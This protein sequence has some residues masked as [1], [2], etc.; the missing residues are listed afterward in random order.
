MDNFNSWDNYPKRGTGLPANTDPEYLDEQ[1]LPYLV[2]P[3]NGSNIGISQKGT[4]SKSFSTV[5]INLGMDFNIF[6]RSFNIVLNVF[7]NPNGTYDN[8]KTITLDDEKFYNTDFE[9]H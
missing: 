8:A 5:S 7:N 6:D 9:I 3:T 1:G 4:L 2:I